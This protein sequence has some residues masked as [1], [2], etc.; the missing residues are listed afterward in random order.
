MATKMV[1]NGLYNELD[2][3]SGAGANVGNITNISGRGESVIPGRVDQP[4][5]GGARSS[6]LEAAIFR[7]NPQSFL[8]LGLISGI[9]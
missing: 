6:L 1:N 3:V 7:G 9:G 5:H 2:C 8:L 4:P